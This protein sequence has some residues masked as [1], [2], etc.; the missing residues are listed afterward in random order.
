MRHD[1]LERGGVL[2]GI[3]TRGEWDGNQA[4]WPD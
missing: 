1:R 3:V 2:L 4:F